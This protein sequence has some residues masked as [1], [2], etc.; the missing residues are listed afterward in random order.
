MISA[1]RCR[2]PSNGAAATSARAGATAVASAI[3]TAMAAALRR[4]GDMGEIS[5]ATCSPCDRGVGPLLGFNAT[6]KRRPGRPGGEGEA[7]PDQALTGGLGIP[8]LRETVERRRHD[9][10]EAWCRRQVG[11][12]GGVDPARLAEFLVEH[13]FAPPPARGKAENDEVPLH[14]GLR[15]VHDGLPKPGDRDG[16]DRL[17][18]LLA[19]LA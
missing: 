14:P 17:A 18:G 19:D 6:E 16:R 15:I 7:M 8:A 10:G 1:S 3:E 11:E 13:R 2:L 4:R 5:V 12:L 9:L